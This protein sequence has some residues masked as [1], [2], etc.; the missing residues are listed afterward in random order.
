MK[1]KARKLSDRIAKLWVSYS[2]RSFLL[3]LQSVQEVCE[4]GRDF[5]FREACCFGDSDGGG[6]ELLELLQFEPNNQC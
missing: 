2:E 3:T 1:L 4:G 5:A 6:V